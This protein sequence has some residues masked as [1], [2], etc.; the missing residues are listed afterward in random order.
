MSKGQFP[1]GTWCKYNVP[2]TSREQILSFNSITYGKDAK[3]IEVKAPWV[4]NTGNISREI[5][6]SYKQTSA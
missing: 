2:S 3:Y 1:A 4:L 5:C 6:K